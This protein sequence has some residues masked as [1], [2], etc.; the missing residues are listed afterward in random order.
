MKAKFKIMD[1]AAKPLELELEH[2][3]EGLTNII[4]KVVGPHSQ[5]F[6]DVQKKIQTEGLTENSNHEVIAA[7]I[8]GWDEESFEMPYTPENAREFVFKPENQWVCNFLAEYVTDLT[9]FFRKKG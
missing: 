2:P 3:I 7:C 4:V 8:V 5:Q 9:L 6:K 1:L